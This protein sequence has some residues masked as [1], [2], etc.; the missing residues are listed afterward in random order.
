MH[1]VRGTLGLYLRNDAHLL[2]QIGDEHRGEDLE[3]LLHPQVDHQT[4][5]EGLNEQEVLADAAE[6]QE[7]PALAAEAVGQPAVRERSLPCAHER[8]AAVF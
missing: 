3:R 8:V 2:V 1:V 5:P 7:V 6:L 4:P